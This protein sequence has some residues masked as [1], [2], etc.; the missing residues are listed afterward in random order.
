MP[1]TLA[2]RVAFCAAAAVLMS[3]GFWAG[4]SLTPQGSGLSG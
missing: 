1:V 4:K 2:Q 3:A